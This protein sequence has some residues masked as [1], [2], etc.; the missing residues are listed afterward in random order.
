[1]NVLTLKIPEDL[2]AALQKASR[3]R[4]LSKS[5]VVREALEASLGRH[6]DDAAA[7][8]RWVAQWRGRLVV[9]TPAPAVRSRRADRSEGSKR[10]SVPDV[11]LAHLLA[12]HL[13]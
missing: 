1:M 2:D 10:P 4:G 11:R 8:E 6:A 9:P 7:A 5:A 13:R 12:K 3:G